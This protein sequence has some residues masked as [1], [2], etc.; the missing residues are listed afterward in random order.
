MKHLISIELKKAL[1][2]KFFI[3]SMILILGPLIVVTPIING[4]YT[5]F[6]PIEVHSEL[7]NSAA[8]SLLFPILLVI[9][10][11]MKG[12]IQEIASIS[13]ESAAGI[14]ETAAASQQTNS[15]MQEVSASAEELAS[16]AE[17]LIQI[18]GQFR[19]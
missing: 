10:E 12:S 19:L 9:G 5:F 6:R 13:E 4:S 15:S 8:I 3:V 7:I 2:L 18:I 11:K 17:E 16:L 14:E 1:S